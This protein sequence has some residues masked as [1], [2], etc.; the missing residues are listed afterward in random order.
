MLLPGVWR[1]PERESGSS[2]QP[3][4]GRNTHYRTLNALHI[5][6]QYLFISFSHITAVPPPTPTPWN[7]LLQ[8]GVGA[9]GGT[10]PDKAE[11]GYT[12]VLSL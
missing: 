11:K 5:L 3:T 2:K 12:A 8:Q 9:G 7:T 10:G 4:I 6:L 1:V